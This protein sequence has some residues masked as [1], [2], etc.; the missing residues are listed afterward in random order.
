M[1]CHDVC[2]CWKNKWN[3]FLVHCSNVKKS[4]R[5]FFLRKIQDFSFQFQW[6][7]YRFFFPIWLIKASFNHFIFLLL[8]VL[9]SFFFLHRSSN[10][11]SK[12]FYS[13]H[14]SLYIFS[15]KIHSTFDNNNC[16]QQTNK[17]CYAGEF[18]K[19]KFFFV[20]HCPQEF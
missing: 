11:Y 8:L 2:C 4:R 12:I 18:S 17:Q 9:S 6:S 19:R 3:F 7:C 1:R 5:I 10:G 16:R 14:E 15:L 20:T 13:I